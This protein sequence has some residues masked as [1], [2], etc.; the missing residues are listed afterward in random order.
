MFPVPELHNNITRPA[1]WPWVHLIP[2][3]VTVLTVS[4]LI[5]SYFEGIKLYNFIWLLRENKQ[6][7]SVSLLK[8]WSWSIF[9]LCLILGVTVTIS[10][11]GLWLGAGRQH[12]NFPLLYH[13][14]QLQLAFRLLWC[15]GDRSLSGICALPTVV[16]FVEILRYIKNLYWTRKRGHS[17]QNIFQKSVAP[18]VIKEFCERFV[19][20]TA[21]EFD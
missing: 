5:Q 10:W 3:S 8:A 13:L 12:H 17:V 11:A 15:F 21:V 2:S 7:H 1:T 9:L 19:I 16:H 18:I 4:F 14:L 6:K 20:A